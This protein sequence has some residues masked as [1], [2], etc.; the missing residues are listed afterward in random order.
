MKNRI[1]KH[2]GFSLEAETIAEIKLK[3]IEEETND[4]RALDLIVPR[5]DPIL[6]I[7]PLYIH[8]YYHNRR[9]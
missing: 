2:K 8:P 3:A 9:I 5:P 4:S 1:R 7:E 6:K